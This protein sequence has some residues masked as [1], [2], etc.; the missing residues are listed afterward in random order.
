MLAAEWPV[1]TYFV[2]S[3]RR[4]AYPLHDAIESWI[5]YLLRSATLTVSNVVA[6]MF[7]PRCS[8]PYSTAVS[9]KLT[10]L[11]L[12]SPKDQNTSGLNTICL[13]IVSSGPLLPS[14]VPKCAESLRL[15]ITK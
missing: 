6:A 8:T 10:T 4:L 13:K 12:I 7:L 3:R 1:P 15:R 14:D 2:L 9:T 11:E 5:L